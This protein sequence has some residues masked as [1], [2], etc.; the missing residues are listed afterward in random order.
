MFDIF[1]DPNYEVCKYDCTPSA[2][3]NVQYTGPPRSGPTSGSC[4]PAL[5]GGSCTGTP[6]ECAECNLVLDCKKED[7]NESNSEESTGAPNEDVCEYKCQ[8]TGGC[9]VI[10]MTNSD[11]HD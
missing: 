2:G 4:F 3:C 8:D 1:S 6:P 5:F 7:V 10:K 11:F 9:Q